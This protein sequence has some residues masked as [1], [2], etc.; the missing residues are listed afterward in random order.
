MKVLCKSLHFSGPQLLNL[1]LN[2]S[3][4]SLVI[5]TEFLLLLSHMKFTL[6]PLELQGDWPEFPPPGPH[7]PKLVMLYGSSARVEST[8]QIFLS[9]EGSSVDPALSDPGCCVWSTP[10]AAFATF[11]LFLS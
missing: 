5:F 2:S 9:E 11:W 3:S 8:S 1:Q 7:F 10:V 4:E 6:I